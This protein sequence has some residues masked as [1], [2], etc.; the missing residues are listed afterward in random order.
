MPNSQAQIGSLFIRAL[1]RAYRPSGTQ[2]DLLQG[3]GVAGANFFILGS[4]AP[5]A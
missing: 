2:V 1:L 4:T 5:L 3:S